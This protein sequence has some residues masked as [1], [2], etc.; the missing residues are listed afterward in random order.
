MLIDSKH[1]PPALKSLELPFPPKIFSLLSGFY[2]SQNRGSGIEFSEL[3]EYVIGDEVRSIDW[4][5]SAR[6][7]ATFVKTYI[8]LRNQDVIFAIDGSSSMVMGGINDTQSPLFIGGSLIGLIMRLAL[9]RGD[10]VGFISSQD[11]S[12]VRSQTT[13]QSTKALSMYSQQY[14]AIS[15]AQYQILH[16]ADFLKKVRLNV[17]RHSLIVFI[18]DDFEVDD[19]ILQQYRLLRASGHRLWCMR[20]HGKTMNPDAV[21]QNYN[22]MDIETGELTDWAVL[23]KRV[24]AEYEQTETQRSAQIDAQ[25]RAVGVEVATLADR[26]GA[27]PLVAHI[28]QRYKRNKNKT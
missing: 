26:K 18:S 14:A 13:G 22:T 15:T 2:N 24:M 3:R 16:W 19:A 4:K 23:D 10:R 11:D 5:A 27:I 12:V 20:V 6:G 8:D 9:N 17:H 7:H 28:L 1:I 25:L 21:L